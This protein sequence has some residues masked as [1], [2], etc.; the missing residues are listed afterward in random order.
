MIKSVFPN[1]EIDIV[2]DT[3]RVY[4]L[5]NEKLTMDECR[6]LVISKKHSILLVHDKSAEFM[7]PS[8]LSKAKYKIT[9]EEAHRIHAYLSGESMYLDQL[10]MEM[11]NFMDSEFDDNHTDS[12][13]LH[14]NRVD[15]DVLPNGFGEF[16]LDVTN[17][18]PTISISGSE[19]YL[20]RLR[21]NGQKIKYERL[22]STVSDV[23]DGC[24]DIYKIVYS[25]ENV[26]KIYICPYHRRNS[27]Q[28][29]IGF[30]YE[31]PFDCSD[32]RE[33]F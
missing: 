25:D 15:S 8:I 18:I 33:N 10:A 24:V 20:S 29:P 12:S 22:G 4:S 32:W 30:T 31:N 26:A 16:G 13:E 14:E 7:I 3:K 6:S 28:A 2:R 21:F 17:P 23:T 11:A 9:G 5:V 19:V 1:G 27:K